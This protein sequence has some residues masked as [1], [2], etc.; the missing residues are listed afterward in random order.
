M[1]VSLKA[2]ALGC[3]SSAVSLYPPVF[4]IKMHKSSPVEGED[5]LYHS[6]LRMLHELSLK[7]NYVV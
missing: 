2:L 6:N 3:V 1:R 5:K 7:P 4:L